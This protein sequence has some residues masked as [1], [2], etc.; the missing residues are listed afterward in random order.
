M[1]RQRFVSA[2]PFVAVVGFLLA[3]PTPGSA[4]LS[5]VFRPG[6]PGWLG[7]VVE[8]SMSAGLLGPG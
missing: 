1:R 2:I 5:D 6:L 7:I 8:R 3:T 4:D